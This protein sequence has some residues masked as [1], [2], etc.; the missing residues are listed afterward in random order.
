MDPDLDPAPYPDPTP[1]PTPFF[2]DFKDA[3][4][5]RFFHIYFLEFAQRHIIFSL[6][7]EI[8]AK[9]LC[10]NFILQAQHIYE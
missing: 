3:K 5:Y 7:N 8:F 9:N 4:K 1:D 6:K 10:T 2:S